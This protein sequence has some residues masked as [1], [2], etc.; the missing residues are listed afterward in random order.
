MRCQGCRKNTDAPKPWFSS[1][2][3]GEYFLEKVL[4]SQKWNFVVDAN[5]RTSEQ[6]NKSKS[7][8]K[9]ARE[10]ISTNNEN[11]FMYHFDFCHFTLNKIN[12][13]HVYATSKWQ[14][15]THQNRV[16]NLLKSKM[17]LTIH[18]LSAICPNGVGLSK[19]KWNN[20]QRHLIYSKDK[21]V[22]SCFLLEYK[23][24]YYSHNSVM[25][26]STKCSA[27]I[28]NIWSTAMIKEV[29]LA[30]FLV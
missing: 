4:Y 14:S 21:G 13:E 25:V 10:N 12:S 6:Q 17:T 8:N 26:L 7:K 11:L 23:W 30:S 1:W 15:M 29:H 22:T 27:T 28:K 9:R 18:P 3:L 19:L 5:P 16:I 2:D 24:Q 20:H